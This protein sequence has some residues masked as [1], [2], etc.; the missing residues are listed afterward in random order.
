[1]KANESKVITQ[2]R[3]SVTGQVISTPFGDLRVDIRVGGY[4]SSEG[5]EQYEPP[6]DNDELDGAEASTEESQN[7]SSSSASHDAGE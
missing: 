5:D 7:A 1:M 2:G 4:K 3:K 6:V